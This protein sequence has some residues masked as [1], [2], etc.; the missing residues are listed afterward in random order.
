[1]LPPSRTEMSSGPRRAVN[2]APLFADLPPPLSQ[3]TASARSRMSAPMRQRGCFLMK[4]RRLFEFGMGGL[5][6]LTVVI[7][8]K[9][10]DIVPEL[11]PRDGVADERL[12][13]LVLRTRQVILRVH[14][15]LRLGPAQLRQQVLLFHPAFGDPTA[16][17]AD[18]IIPLGLIEGAPAIAHL[19]FD[20]VG[21]LF[22]R[23]ASRFIRDE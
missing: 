1:M 16:D 9:D 11:Q 23:A 14:L 12:R 20:F 5:L 19:E 21:A 18:F 6:P 13:E 3:T 8:I 10:S 22:D 15:V 17:F 7:D 4:T 2:V